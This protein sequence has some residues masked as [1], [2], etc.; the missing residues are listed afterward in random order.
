MERL[1]SSTGACDGI[2]ISESNLKEWQRLKK[3]FEEFQILS[4]AQE[5]EIREGIEIW[6]A[7]N[8]NNQVRHFEDNLNEFAR[9]SDR[10]IDRGWFDTEGNIHI[11]A[12]KQ[13]DRCRAK[14]LESYRLCEG[15]IIL[16]ANEFCDRLYRLE[17]VTTGACD[18]LGHASSLRAWK[19]LKITICKDFF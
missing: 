9:W 14:T 11:P 16:K 17:Q 15:P 1:E 12:G 8:C 18:G 7:N 5:I 19:D 2:S 4:E 10:M 3:I 13:Y 6:K